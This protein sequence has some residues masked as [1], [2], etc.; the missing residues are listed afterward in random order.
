MAVL[1][2]VLG[3]IFAMVSQSAIVPATPEQVYLFIFGVIGLIGY[4]IA[5]QNVQNGSII[6]AVSGLALIG[7]V[8]DIAAD[9]TVA[10]LTGFLLLAGAI[11]SL[12]STR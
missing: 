11:W 8:A 4:G 1:F 5:K 6:S 10:L 9:S 2:S 3:Y 12:A 7:V